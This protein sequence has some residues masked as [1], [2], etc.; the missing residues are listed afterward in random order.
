L[1]ANGGLLLLARRSYAA[2]IATAVA[3]ETASR[4]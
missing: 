3:S 2:D 4:R 1:A